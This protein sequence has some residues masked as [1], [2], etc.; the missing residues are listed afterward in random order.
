MDIRIQDF[1]RSEYLEIYNTVCTQNLDTLNEDIKIFRIFYQNFD[2]I[3]ESVKIVDKISQNEL[4]FKKF[5]HELNIN[6]PLTYGTILLKYKKLYDTVYAINEY[7]YFLKDEIFKK[8]DYLKKFIENYE[9][10]LDK[11]GIKKD[12]SLG[13]VKLVV[14]TEKINIFNDKQ[15][16]KENEINFFKDIKDPNK[17]RAIVCDEDNVKVV[18]GAGAGKT[19]IIEKR[20]NYLIKNGIDPKRFYVYVILRRELIN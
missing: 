2:K 4:L 8:I 11:I 9:I 18:A 17:K 15:T 7:P 6:K 20:V 1:I 10:L 3:E 12:N 5:F 14:L 16:E 13:N 19:F